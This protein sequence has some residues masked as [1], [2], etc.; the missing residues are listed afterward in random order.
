MQSRLR[1]GAAVVAAVLLVAAA[2]QVRADVLLNEILADP[3]S[4]W[5]GSGELHSRDDEFVEIVNTGPGPVDLDGYRLAGEDGSWRYAFTGSLGAGAVRVVYGSQSYAW[6]R[7]TGN[8]AYGLRLTNTG[9]GIALWHLAGA[10]TTMVDCYIYVDHE[11]D[12][13]RSSGRLPDGADNWQLFDGMNPYDGDEPPFGSICTPTPG[14]TIS[15]PT[16][17]EASTWGRI[18]AQF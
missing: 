11:A 14:S 3:A 2:E 6:E 4:D 1:L 8:P 18:K 13:D 7:E 10:D 9:G 16:P 15:C 12:D 17:I 5:D